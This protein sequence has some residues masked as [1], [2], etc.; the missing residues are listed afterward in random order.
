MNID[1]ELMDKA[2]I[3]SDTKFGTCSFSLKDYALGEEAKQLVRI[4]P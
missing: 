3:G 4:L 2:M 1:V